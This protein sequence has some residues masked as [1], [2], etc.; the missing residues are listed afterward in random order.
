MPA[1]PFRYRDADGNLRL[2]EALGERFVKHYI[3]VLSSSNEQFAAM[4]L[5]AAVRAPAVDDPAD[6]TYSWREPRGPLV[7]GYELT[8]GGRGPRVCS[9]SQALALLP[10]VCWD[11]CGYYRMLGVH[12]K[13]TN[14]EI[15]LA[16]LEKDPRQE[17]P[18]LFYA[19][20][21]LLDPLIRRAYDLM[22]LGELFMGDRNVRERID[23]AAAQEASR[24]NADAWLAGEA[25]DEKEQNKDVLREWGFER[26]SSADEA[27]E[28]LRAQYASQTPLGS[29]ETALGK[30]L[31]GWDRRWGYYHLVD[32][33]DDTPALDARVLEIWQALLCRALSD[34][35]VTVAFSVGTWP[36]H[37]PKILLDS[38]EPCIIFFIGNE[39]PNPEL[40]TD[41]VS[42][43]MA[44]IEQEQEK[45][46]AIFR[47][48]RS[49][50][51][52]GSER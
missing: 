17:D 29:E 23:A 31:S 39:P 45:T 38:N 7:D 41:A 15:R 16:Y 26:V 9:S 21:Q 8:Q 48:R 13:A 42:G 50:S 33:Y 30:T 52:S 14:K 34:R 51:S 11:V 10:E 32:P 47:R 36:G 25:Y 18:D 35:G 28:R 40:A 24:R 37:G 46:H 5:T 20:S 22:S 2:D 19:M 43:Y 44:R 49:R 3:D 4:Q 27:R 1:E 6:Q 12:W